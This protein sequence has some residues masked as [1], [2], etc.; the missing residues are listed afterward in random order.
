MSNSVE[1]LYNTTLKAEMLGLDRLRMGLLGA[2][3]LL[4]ALG[5]FWVWTTVSNDGS[6]ALGLV[7]GPL[8]FLVFLVVVYVPGRRLYSNRFRLGVIRPFLQSVLPAAHYIPDEGVRQESF[9]KALFFGESISR[10]QSSDYVKC[11]IGSIPVVICFVEA[12]GYRASYGVVPVFTGLFA[13]FPLARKVSS[14][15]VIR[16]RDKSTESPEIGAAGFS[17]WLLGEGAF[18]QGFALFGRNPNL[19]GE[20]V[21]ETVQH[22]LLQC[23]Q[24]GAVELSVQ[25]AYGYLALSLPKSFFEPSVME[26]IRDVSELVRIGFVLRSIQQLI[27]AVDASCQS[28]SV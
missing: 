3:S 25:G 20:L 24:F 19:V 22:L 9:E 21:T 11:Q 1:T 15:V 12:T 17:E 2:C 10:Y 14:P 26:P 7:A 5:G 27:Q 28:L 13:A 16:T 8:A 6:Q 23:R 18:Q 4:G